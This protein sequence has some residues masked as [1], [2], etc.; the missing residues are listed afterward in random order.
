MD[1]G[2]NTTFM[3]R[4]GVKVELGIYKAVEPFT[5]NYRTEI[6][7]KDDNWCIVG[8]PI[9]GDVIEVHY[10]STS[11][12]AK[13]SMHKKME[14][15]R[16]FGEDV[17]FIDVYFAD[18]RLD[19]MELCDKDFSG[20]TPHT[21]IR[22]RKLTHEQ[23]INVATKTGISF[24][25]I[26]E[27]QGGPLPDYME[28]EEIEYLSN[29]ILDHRFARYTSSYVHEDGTIGYNYKLDRYCTPEIL[30]SEAVVLAK[31]FDFLDMIIAVSSWATYPDVWWRGEYEVT[32]G[33]DRGDYGTYR[34]TNLW[35]EDFNSVIEFCVHI[36]DGKVYW[37]FNEEA[38]K[39][40]AEYDVVDED[41]FFDDY[42]ELNYISEFGLG[43]FRECIEYAGFDFDELISRYRGFDWYLEGYNLTT[44][45]EIDK[46]SSV[47]M[48]MISN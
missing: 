10:F 41:R 30:A 29:Q 31:E 17:V 44:G 46:E 23:L 3:G 7:Y 22:G 5:I 32:K 16:E 40:Y 28:N 24:K 33:I 26:G 19:Y 45:E 21:R 13:Y 9:V 37:A 8:K 14:E 48:D 20:K 6:A 39:M 42:N 38:K 18:S 47:Y 34:D 4:K 1:N 15:L 35:K 27:F 11:P 2:D 43:F 12:G 36:K 25:G